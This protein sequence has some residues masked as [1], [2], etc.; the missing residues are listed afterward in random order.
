MPMSAQVDKDGVLHIQVS[1]PAHPIP[2]PHPD[3]QMHDLVKAAQGIEKELC[4]AN[5]LYTCINKHLLAISVSL[6]KIAK[7]VCPGDPAGV[8]VH[9]GKIDPNPEGSVPM[10]AKFKAAWSKGGM[11]ASAAAAPKKKFTKGDALGGDIAF[12]AGMGDTVSIQV[13][14]NHTPPNILDMTGKATLAVTSAD[15]AIV[16]ADT[17]VDLTYRE[18]GLAAGTSAISFTISSTDGSFPDI[19]GSY[20][21]TVNVAP[22]GSPSGFIVVHGPIT[23]NP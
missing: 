13:T 1:D 8:L 22:P 2:K 11:K 15:P 6:E 23:I 14:D 5:G 3:P 18:S 12:D 9:H 4:V 10:T 17:V 20:T 7:C 19:S 21:D 16:R